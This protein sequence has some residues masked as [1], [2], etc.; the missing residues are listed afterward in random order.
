MAAPIRVGGRA[1]KL[2]RTRELSET[3]CPCAKKPPDVSCARGNLRRRLHT[4]QLE[5]TRLVCGP[6]GAAAVSACGLMAA[7]MRVGG[8]ASKLKRTRKLS[9]PQCP[10][11]KRPPDVSCAPSNLHRRLHAGQL[12]PMRLVCGPSGAAAVS[13]RGLM[14]APIRVGRPLN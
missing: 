14:A 8:R 3:Q 6:S 4:G 9:E 10:C 2:K 1:S 12:E 13:L 5:P 11:A 7:P